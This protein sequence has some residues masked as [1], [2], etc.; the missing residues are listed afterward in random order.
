M[1]RR[2]FGGGDLDDRRYVFLLNFTPFC[3]RFWNKR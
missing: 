2:F 3:M 1:L